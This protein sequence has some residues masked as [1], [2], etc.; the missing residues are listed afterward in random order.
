MNIVIK[1]SDKPN[2]K[3]MA[4]IDNKKT[5]HVGDDRYQDFTTH[6]NEA[7]RS[8]IYQDIKMIILQT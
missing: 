6:K 8:H 2:K 3:I 1:P 5:I 7:G 4:V